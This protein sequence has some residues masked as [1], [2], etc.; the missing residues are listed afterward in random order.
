MFVS[1]NWRE[2]MAEAAKTG[3]PIW[4][5]PDG[6]Y[7][8]AD[9]HE[10]AEQADAAEWVEVEGVTFSDLERVKAGATDV[11]CVE[12]GGSVSPRETWQATPEGAVICSECAGGVA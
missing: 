9:A 8:V 3:K 5:S 7:A 6:F 12:C 10:F 1:K 11:P 4:R 2:A